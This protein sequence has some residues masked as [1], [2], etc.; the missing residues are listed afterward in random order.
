M[1]RLIL[2]MAIGAF[3]ISIFAQDL[4]K[5][6]KDHYKASGQEKISQISS[7]TMKGKVVAM[8]MEAPISLYRARPGKFRMEMT[9]MGS[10]MLTIFN[11]T[12]GWIHA[13]GMGIAQP[14]E[15]GAEELK[16]VVNQADMDSPLWDY[17]AKG[18]KLEFAGTSDDGSDYKIKLTTAEGTEMFICIN[19]ETS[20]MS[21]IQTSQVVNGIESEI[22]VE[23]KDYKNV[24]GI[25][26]AHYMGTKMGGQ[27]I[28]TINFES[29]E[30]NNKLD[31]ALF[32]KPA[33]Q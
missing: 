17:E 22:E 16:N 8:G 2:S 21:K 9:M 19:K 33:V 31:P 12:T 6:L 29:I 1:R 26:T 20:L 10:V 5:I 14:Q 27:P 11:G 13:P 18:N 4:D 15:M 25:P 3:A 7:A 24:K 30:Y 23:F 28:S 32:E